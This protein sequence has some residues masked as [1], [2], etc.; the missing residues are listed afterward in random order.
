[1]FAYNTLPNS[2]SEKKTY[3]T[4]AGGQNG[5]VQ[6]MP[7]WQAGSFSRTGAVAPV[8]SNTSEKTGLI[9]IEYKQQ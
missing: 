8:F 3:L 5:I 2:I 1:M 9:Y 6:Q 4:I 7:M